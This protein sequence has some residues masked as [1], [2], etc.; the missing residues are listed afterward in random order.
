MA[1]TVKKLLLP[2]NTNAALLL[3]SA[4]HGVAPLAMSREY[5]LQGETERKDTARE[6]IQQSLANMSLDE[7]LIA[8][9]LKEHGPTQKL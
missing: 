4:A 3:K 9:Y 7:A 2:L 5:H 6:Y 1:A 8:G